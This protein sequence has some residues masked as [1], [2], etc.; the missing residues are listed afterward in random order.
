[1]KKM[2]F[3]L[4]LPILLVG[5]CTAV[6]IAQVPIAWVM[7]LPYA[8]FG[9]HTND[10]KAEQAL[11]GDQRCWKRMG[12]NGKPITFCMYEW[13]WDNYSAAFLQNGPATTQRFYYHPYETCGLPY[14]LATT[15]KF[16]LCSRTVKVQKIYVGV[17]TKR[18]RR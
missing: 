4:L 11:R 14:A 1:M 5:A 17:G 16:L 9:G 8:Y 3:V 2:L 15:R 6:S 18:N 13:E 12:D 7:D 10:V